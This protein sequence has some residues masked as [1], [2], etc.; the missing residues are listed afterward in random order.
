MS[1]RGCTNCGWKRFFAHQT[2][3]ADIVVDEENDFIENCATNGEIIAE[4]AGTPFGP[5]ICCNCGMQYD[6]I[7]EQPD[8]LEKIYCLGCGREMLT[9]GGQLCLRCIKACVAAM[10]AH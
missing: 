2:V 8:P 6:D 4:S 3:I 5:Y 1:K 10:D 7:P 9:E